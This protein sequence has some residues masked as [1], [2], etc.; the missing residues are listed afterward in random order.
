M[1]LNPAFFSESRPFLPTGIVEIFLPL[2]ARKKSWALR[3]IL[4]LN[5]PAK[6]RSPVRTS[7]RILSSGRFANSGCCGSL[8]RDMIE[9]SIRASSLA[10]GRAANREGWPSLVVKRQSLFCCRGNGRCEAFLESFDGGLDFRL[11]AVVESLFCRNALQNRRV[12][13]LDKL[14]EFSLKTPNFRDRNSVQ[15]AARRHIKNQH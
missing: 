15:H 7:A 4:A 3:R 1:R 9:R 13:G 8:M 11:D 2:L 12:I 6:P 14:Q 10:Y 5:A